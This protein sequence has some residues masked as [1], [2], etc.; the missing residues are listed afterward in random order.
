M[1][2]LVDG[3][4][5]QRVGLGDAVVG[6]PREERRKAALYSRSCRL[7]PASPGPERVAVVGVVVVVV[8]VGEV[9]VGDGDAGLLGAAV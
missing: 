6:E 2:A 8:D 9:R 3:D 7:M 4:Q 5:E 1:V